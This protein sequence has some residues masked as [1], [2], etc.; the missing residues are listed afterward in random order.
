MFYVQGKK[1]VCN[2]IIRFLCYPLA[3]ALWY[4]DD[5]TL[6]ADSCVFRLHTNSYSLH[7]VE[8]LRCALK[9]NFN[10]VSTIHGEENKKQTRVTHNVMGT[11]PMACVKCD[12]GLLFQPDVQEK[13]YILHIGA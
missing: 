12:R 5:G 10:I 1:V 11:A 2:N 8:L 4:L 9:E 3:L 13:R 6:R 7:D